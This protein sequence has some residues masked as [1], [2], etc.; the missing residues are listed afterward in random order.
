MRGIAEAAGQ[1]LF[2][3]LQRKKRGGVRE[4]GI[5]SMRLCFPFTWFYFM[6]MT[7]ANLQTFGG[8]VEDG[9]GGK[10]HPV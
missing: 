2:S 1:T 4:G 7:T 9:V 5:K 6:R 8:S 10:V 3:I